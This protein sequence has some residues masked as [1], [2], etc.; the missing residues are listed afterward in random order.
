MRGLFICK[1]VLLLVFSV[2][3]VL[4]IKIPDEERSILR[5]VVKQIIVFSQRKRKPF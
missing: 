1:S 4:E 5:N 3:A 2:F